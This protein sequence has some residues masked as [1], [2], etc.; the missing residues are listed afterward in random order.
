MLCVVLSFCNALSCCVV[1][2]LCDYVII[3]I[4][5]EIQSVVGVADGVFLL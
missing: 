3:R 2:L 4:R 5:L 1:M